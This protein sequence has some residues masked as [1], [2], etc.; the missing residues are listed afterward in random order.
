MRRW[1]KVSV[2]AAAVLGVG[3]YVAE[4]YAQDWLLTRNACGGALPRDAVQQLAPKDSH[5]EAEE[6]KQTKALGS[7]GCSLTVKGDEVNDERLVRMAAYTRRDDQD[8]EFMSIFPEE[9]FSPQ[10]PLPEGL[11]GFIDRFGSIQLL[12]PCPD[13]GKDA[14]GRQRKLLVRTWMGR[15]VNTG[16]PG[17][18]YRTAVALA[19]SASER[20]GCGAKPLNA[21]KG[22]AV[23]ADPEDDPKTVPLSQAKNTGCGWATRSGLPQSTDWRVE[24]GTNDAAPTGRCRLYSGD[25]ESTHERSRM[26]FVG[27]YGDWSNRLRAEDG[28]GE[29]LPMTAT[30]RCEGEAA[31]FALS[32]SDD[33]PGV[34]NAMKQR[35]FKEFAQDQV[36]RRGCSGLRFSL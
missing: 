18:A 14:E 1:V 17:A 32:A 9:G 6:S 26:A 8:R 20:F 34:G 3:G 11:P 28:N 33:I 7:Y 29:P 31:N 36:R 13:L 4:P 21:P 2:A 19:N 27:W 24:V 5:M 15:D 12:L 23:P 10:A 35:M 22:D 16:V 30:A 25:Q